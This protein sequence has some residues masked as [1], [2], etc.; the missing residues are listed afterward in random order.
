MSAPWQN[1]MA[2]KNNTRTMGTNSAESEDPKWVQ[3]QAKVCQEFQCAT[4]VPPICHPRLKVFTR[5]CNAYLRQRTF[6]IEDLYKDLD[7]GIL[8]IQLLE[9]L[10]HE[11]LLKYNKKPKACTST[12]ARQT[13]IPST[14][15]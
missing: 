4:P 6:K 3:Q 14:P 1:E 7:D 2:R 9:I 13:E 11:N 15:L 8:L 10:G 5:W 12:C